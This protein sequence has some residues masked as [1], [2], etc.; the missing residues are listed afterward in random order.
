MP[1]FFLAVI[2]FFYA[3]GPVLEAVGG[4]LLAIFT[5]LLEIAKIT[6]VMT[7]I[8]AAFE[9]LF[10]PRGKQRVG[11]LL[12]NIVG[13][14]LGA[15]TELIKDLTPDLDGVRS[16]LSTEISTA[17]A[18]LHT[19]LQVD[20]EPFVQAALS[21]QQDAFESVVI[22]TPEN[23]LDT[24]SLAF[25]TAFGEGLASFAVSA[26]FEALLPEKLNT[27]NGIGPILSKLAGFDEVAGEVISPLYRNAFG[28]S[29]EYKY[30]SQF[31]PD[32]PREADAVEWHS[33]RLDKG[34]KLED[35]FAV[36]G[37][38]PQFEEAYIAGAYRPISVRA[39]ASAFVD[40][41]VPVKELRATMEFTGNRDADINL[42]LQAIQLQSVKSLRSGY[43]SAVMTAA[44]RGTLTAQEVTDA[45]TNSES[46][47]DGALLIQLTIAVRK[48]EQLAEIY[49]K[50]ITEGY[51]T[52]QITDAEYLPQLEAIG[53]AQADAEAHYAVDA[54]KVRGK[55]LSVEARAA[56][57]AASVLQRAQIQAALAAFRST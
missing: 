38:K 52:G 4:A 15:A 13:G 16:Q 11:N 19:A 37:L 51:T 26:A 7:L 30:A 34:W 23:A 3:V 17:G 44:E 48:L 47:T 20:F 42:M 40:V 55:A 56:A 10:D 14:G 35:V 5:A 9:I 28:K 31:K 57:K 53:I 36:S 32:F 50:S 1:A 24:A 27:L 43:L 18:A 29:L 21:A 25:S 6:A 45:V 41:P 22:S 2:Q 12:A 8:L 54:I 46:I 49:R 33:R 39:M